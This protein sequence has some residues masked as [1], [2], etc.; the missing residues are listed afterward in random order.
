MLT[1]MPGENT[2]LSK[3]FY[4]VNRIV[5]NILVQSKVQAQFLFIAFYQLPLIKSLQ[6]QQPY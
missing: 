1:P 4:Q 5:N 6:K 2:F 3:L